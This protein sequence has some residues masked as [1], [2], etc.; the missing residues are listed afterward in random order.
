MNV[1]SQTTITDRK[2]SAA[3]VRAHADQL[4]RLAGEVGVS[5]VRLR[6]EGT[7]VV[8]SDE[9]GY[10]QVVDLSRRISQVVGCYVHVIT[11]DVPAAADARPV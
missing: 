10:R 6:D 11:D 1:V 9:L 3:E 8:H 4:H 7:V 5:N 2:A